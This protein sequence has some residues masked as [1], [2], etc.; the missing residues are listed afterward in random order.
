MKLQ[1]D[2][3]FNGD[4]YVWQMEYPGNKTTNVQVAYDQI[5]SPEINGYSYISYILHTGMLWDGTIGDATVTMSTDTGGAFL[6]ASAEE[7]KQSVS[8]QIQ[9]AP[10]SLPNNGLPTSSAPN[11]VSWRLTD[12]K[13]SF[14]PFVF[15]VPS[16]AWRRLSGAEARL[17]AGSASADDYA[18]GVQ[19]YFDSRG[20]LPGGLPSLVRH[21]APQALSDRLDEAAG[22]AN[23]AVNL[24]PNNPAAARLWRMCNT[25][26]KR[27]ELCF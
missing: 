27:V 7:A 9:P 13:P 16:D 8:S 22:W 18:A 20:R 6:L 5:I 26:R 21:R 23:Q 25:S 15:Y 3:I 2:S 11:Q 24:D 12:F 10:D 19:A 1:P 14:D 17:G 4:W